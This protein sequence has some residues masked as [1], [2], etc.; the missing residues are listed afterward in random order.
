MEN[1]FLIDRGMTFDYGWLFDYG[2][3]PALIMMSKDR[4]VPFQLKIYSSEI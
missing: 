2:T 4:W 1:N 3:L